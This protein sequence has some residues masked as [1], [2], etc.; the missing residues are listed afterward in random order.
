MVEI[1]KVINSL[2]CSWIKRIQE[3]SNDNPLKRLNYN[4][5]NKYG[6]YLISES[7]L[8]EKDVKCIFNKL[9]FLKDI[10]IA[11]QNVAHEDLKPITPQTVIWNNSI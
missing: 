7:Y 1:E 2:K 8:T 4:E 11:W 5:P 10:I 9:V 3:L 6:G